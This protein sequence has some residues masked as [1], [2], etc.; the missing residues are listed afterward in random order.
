VKVGL[1]TFPVHDGMPPAELARVA[2]GAG[3]ESLFVTEHSHIPA[4]RE[5]P[6]PS[7]EPLPRRYYHVYDPFVALTA[8]A[9]VTTTLR[10]GTG[11]CLAAQRDPIT[12]AKQTASLDHLSGGRFLFGVGAGWNREEMRNH[13]VD[14]RL[15]FEILTEHVEAIRAIWTQDEASYHGDHVSFDRIWS[16]PKPAQ[17]SG[18]P[19]LVGGN[20]PT[21]IDR[22]VRF[23][24]EWF[25]LAADRRKLARQ[26]AELR[27]KAG[28]T[29]P[30]TLWGGASTPGDLDELTDLGVH[31]VLLPL[32]D[33]D[34]ADVLAQIDRY[35]A[36]I[37][38]VSAAAD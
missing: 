1:V 14:S 2:E 13:G 18:P 5:S 8:A 20:G 22:V 7:G 23:G 37:S 24:D 6:S 35:A 12:L 26:A 29:V 4:S 33:A 15:R 11:I 3:F 27:T 10:L 36:L 32:R 9:T 25:P 17:P 19:V 16:W 21:V 30:I 28:R 31:R 34:R 38:R